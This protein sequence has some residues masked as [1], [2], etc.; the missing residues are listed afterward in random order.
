MLSNLI[1]A[2]NLALDQIASLNEIIAYSQSDGC[3]YD[4]TEKTN[5]LESLFFGES[6]LNQVYLTHVPFSSVQYT[7]SIPA[8]IYTTIHTKTM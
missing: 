2:V 4:V 5:Y 1:S 6:E 3:A 8:G 7:D